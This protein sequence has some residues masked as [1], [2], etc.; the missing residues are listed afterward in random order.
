MLC[1][2][3]R[4]LTQCRVIEY[5]SGLVRI[6]PELDQID[7]HNTR[8]VSRSKERPTLF[9]F[10]CKRILPI[11]RRH[12]Q[13]GNRLLDSNYAPLVHSDVWQVLPLL[14]LL[15]YQRRCYD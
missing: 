9:E 3:S 13:S 12:R 5:R 11:F 7:L 15:I 14:L 10:L 6:R 2:S 1:D 4:K 8:E